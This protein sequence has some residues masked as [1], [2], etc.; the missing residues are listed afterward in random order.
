MEHLLAVAML[1]RLRGGFRRAQL[2]SQRSRE[3]ARAHSTLQTSSR[4]AGGLTAA[5]PYATSQLLKSPIVRNVPILERSFISRSSDDP[6]PRRRMAKQ[7][8][9]LEERLAA[10]V[11]RL[12]EQAKSL[13]PGPDR[14]ALE[15]KAHQAETGLHM[16]DWLRSPGLQAE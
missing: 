13:P 15:L 1:D 8:R 7:V 5:R 4:W 9:T 3:G 11:Q 12:R 6:M 14:E 2:R 10:E 16:M